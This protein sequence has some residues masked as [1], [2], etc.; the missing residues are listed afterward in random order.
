MS[1]PKRDSIYTYYMHGTDG[2][3]YYRLIE[4]KFYHKM[5]RDIISDNLLIVNK[6]RNLLFK[7]DN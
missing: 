4:C 1:I 3:L 5:I 6:L 7:G 2:E